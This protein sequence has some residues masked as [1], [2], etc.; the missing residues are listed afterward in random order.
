[1]RPQAQARCSGRAGRHGDERATTPRLACDRPASPAATSPGLAS[2]RP[3][4]A[5]A[6]SCKDDQIVRRIGLDEFEFGVAVPE[7]AGEPCQS[8]G[9]GCRSPGWFAAERLHQRKVTRDVRHAEPSVHVPAYESLSL[10]LGLLDQINKLLLRTC[11]RRLL[12][13]P[14]RT[15]VSPVRPSRRCVLRT[16]LPKRGGILLRGLRFIQRFN[17]NISGIFPFACGPVTDRRCRPN[18]TSRNLNPMI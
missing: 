12:V 16:L 5:G 2:R 8:L 1:M 10:S 14:W 6:R 3:R 9:T 7:I 18:P 17:L 13:R 4:R 15:A 11:R